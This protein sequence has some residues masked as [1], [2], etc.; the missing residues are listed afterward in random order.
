MS[1]FDI[2]W[3]IDWIVFYAVSEIIQ[4][5]NGGIRHSTL[6]NIEE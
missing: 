6:K 2:D 5:Y 3:L 1:I 4:Q